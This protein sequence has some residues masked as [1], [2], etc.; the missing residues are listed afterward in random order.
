MN[1][2]ATYT[3]TIKDVKIAKSTRNIKGK[4]YVQYTITIPKAF[5][6]KTEAE[7]IKSV[8]ITANDMFFGVPPQLLLQKSK[9]ELVEEVETLIFWL[10]KHVKEVRSEGE[11]SL[12]K[13]EKINNI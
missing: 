13:N 2:T 8:I 5:G 1:K 6:E 7:G 9:E 12:L 11:R 4:D 10:K 3:P